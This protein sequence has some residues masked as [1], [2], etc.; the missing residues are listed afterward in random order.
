MCASPL[1]SEPQLAAILRPLRGNWAENY[2]T[3]IC[4]G[5]FGVKGSFITGSQIWEILV[6]LLVLCYSL[7]H[8]L[9]SCWVTGLYKRGS[10]PAPSTPT[11]VSG[12][13]QP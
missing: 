1:S 6:L 5:N 4:K 11:R 8:T 3:V 7:E 10:P 13:C 12:V 2:N 9:A